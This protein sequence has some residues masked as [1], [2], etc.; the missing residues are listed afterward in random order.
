M[1]TF[2]SLKAVVLAAEED[3]E[4]FF[5]K[6]NKTAGTRLRLAMQQVKILSQQLRVEVSAGK[7]K[8]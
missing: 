1:K 5:I 7:K 8:K 2:D 6:G 4:N 3:S